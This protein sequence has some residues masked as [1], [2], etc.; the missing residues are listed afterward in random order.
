MELAEQDEDKVSVNVGQ[1]VLYLCVGN[2]GVGY[3][4]L[5]CGDGGVWS[6][7]RDCTGKPADTIKIPKGVVTNYGDGDGGGGASEG[8]EGTSLR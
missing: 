3:I 2:K 4:I 8:G 7:N 5:T 6:P 1:E